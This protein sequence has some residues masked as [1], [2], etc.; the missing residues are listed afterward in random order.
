MSDKDKQNQDSQDND[1]QKKLSPDTSSDEDSKM[2]LDEKAMAEFAALGDDEPDEMDSGSKQDLEDRKSSNTGDLRKT[3]KNDESSNAQEE[4]DE[5]V[6]DIVDEVL[7]GGK[8]SETSDTK[9]VDD[10]SKAHEEALVAKDA[11]VA[12]LKEEVRLLKEKVNAFGNVSNTIKEL[13]FENMNQSELV[14]NMKDLKSAAFDYIRNPHFVE[15]LDGFASGKFQLTDRK[16]KAAKDF[17]PKDQEEDF[18]YYD[19]INDPNS[20]SWKAREGW[21]TYRTEEKAEID[22]LRRKIHEFKQRDS[23]APESELQK[24]YAE[25]KKVMDNV[26]TELKAF[27]KSEYEEGEAVFKSF[28][29]KFKSMDIEI[30]KVALAVSARKS[31]VQSR[32]M[33]KIKEN[34]DK[35]SLEGSVSNSAESASDTALYEQTT[36]KEEEFADTF[37][38][39]ET[40]AGVV[41]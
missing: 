38:D 8:S 17:M 5:S 18:D 22:S 11:E 39:W 10:S 23:S 4:P 19:S 12:T 16:V 29:D 28:Y 36:E 14:E 13:G 33:Q 6:Q 37:T 30:F 27:A 32:A 1:L 24:K 15:I 21:E 9:K 3:D 41:R 25:S 35:L 40:N 34:Q 20:P 31:G 7:D 26:M 2:Y